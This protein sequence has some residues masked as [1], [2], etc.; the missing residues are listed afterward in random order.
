MV[1]HNIHDIMPRSVANGPGKR[2]VVWYQGCTLGCAFCFNKP[3]HSQAGGDVLSTGELLAML[4]LQSPAQRSAGLDG[5]TISGGEPLQQAEAVAELVEAL[6]NYHPDLSII[7]LTGFNSL[8]L[9]SMINTNQHV[10]YIMQHVDVVIAGRY[11][12]TQRAAAGYIGSHNKEIIMVTRKHQ[13]H[14]F[15][16]VPEWEVGFSGDG[17][18]RITGVGPEGADE[19]LKLIT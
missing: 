3:T 9:E 18:I 14:E 11:D 10:A 19:L 8:Q 1:T 16:S 17:V 6:R 15:E 13:L 7:V 4:N 5:I 2:M 12:V